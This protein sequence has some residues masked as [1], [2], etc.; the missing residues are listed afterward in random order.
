MSSKV[1]EAGAGVHSLAMAVA[2]GLNHIRVQNE[3][4]SLT[5]H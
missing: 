3:T 5:A 1:A 2:V 4:S